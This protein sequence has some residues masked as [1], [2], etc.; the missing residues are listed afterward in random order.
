MK[1]G[2]LMGGVS[3]EREVS[4]LSGEEI[5]KYMDKEKY[6]VFPI[7]IDSKDEVLEKVR[8]LDFVFLALHGAFGE[9][10][11]IQALLESISTTYS[12]C[13]VLT[14]ALC[15]SKKQSKRILKA[16]GIITPPGFIVNENKELPIE[17]IEALGYPLV[18]KPNNGGSSVG[19]FIV[20]NRKALMESIEKAFKYDEQLLVEKYL[21]GEEYTIPVLNG[22][23]LPIL[24]IKAKGEFFDYASKYLDGGAE[25]VVAKLP[26][27]LEEEMN[28]IAIAC[29]EIFDCRAYVRIDIIVHEGVPYVLEL[30]TLPGMTKNS[31]FP[32][33]ASFAGMEYSVLLDDIIRASQDN[34]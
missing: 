16:E 25:E 30:N 21:E 14:S 20:S 24:Q 13:G 3:S 32:R 29:W 1:V 6:E 28:K 19:T 18:V 22:E 2:V 31:L 15:M 9:D 10:G 12:G 4:L 5:I 34:S 26:K 8:G 11:S 27:G 7:V 17:L 23:V 33:S